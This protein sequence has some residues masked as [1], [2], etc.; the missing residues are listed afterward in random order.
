MILLFFGPEKTFQNILKGEYEMK[1]Y[2]LLSL[3]VGLVALLPVSPANG[4][5]TITQTKTFSGIPSFTDTLTFDY[6]DPCAGRQCEL[7]SEWAVLDSVEITLGM[8]IHD[9]FHHVDNDSPTAASPTVRFGADGILE[10][11]SG[12]LLLPTVDAEVVNQK[13]FNLAADNGDG[14]PFDPC[15]PDGATFYG[16]P[17]K[18][19][20][21]T[22]IMNAIVVSS[23]IGTGTF[24]IDI[25][26]GAINEM[27]DGG[28]VQGQYS[29]VSADGIVEIVYKYHCVPEPATIGLLCIGA[30]ALAR[31]RRRR[32]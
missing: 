22:E 5:F 9:G 16:D 23:F 31:R 27:L 32:A 8:A 29:P 12:P 7:L 30:A 26:T 1:R 19:G 18:V 13:L 15:A 21:V 4:Q 25:K 24:T 17:C 3:A 10:N 28:G 14:L 2:L 11:S 20:S 6:F